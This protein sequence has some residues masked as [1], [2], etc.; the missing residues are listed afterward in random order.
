MIHVVNFSF[1]EGSWAAAKVLAKEVGVENMILL[2]AD[3]LWEDE[4]TYK[5]GED[6]AAN[7]GAK[8][9]RI[10]DGRNPLQVFRD[11]RYLGNSRADPCSKILKRELCDR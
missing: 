11:E 4:E 10:A 9:V 5:W 3:T 2:F 1:G 8:L 7:V 6:A